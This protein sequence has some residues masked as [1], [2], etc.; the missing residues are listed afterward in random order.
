[1]PIPAVHAEHGGEQLD[2]AVAGGADDEGG[3]AGVLVGVDLVE[4]LRVDARQDR[5]HHLR[6]HPFDRARGDAG[7]Q[8][9][10]HAQH[11][12]RA[13]VGRAAQAVAQVLHRPARQLTAADDPVPRRDAGEL[14]PT[15]PRHQGL[16]QIEEGSSAL[17][18][19]VWLCP[20]SVGLVT[21][22]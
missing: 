9:P 17:Q 1:M 15:R 4:H 8:V 21:H 18:T 5:R 13:L 12:A 22:N 16:V 11:I 20:R 3:A 2:H 10:R 7:D 19:V 6:V 14:H